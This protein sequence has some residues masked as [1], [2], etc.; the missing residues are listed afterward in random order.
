M[1]ASEILPLS[2]IETPN[3]KLQTPKKSQV[4]SS[5]TRP[6]LRAWNLELGASLVFGAWCLGFGVSFSGNAFAWRSPEAHGVRVRLG[7]AAVGGSGG[8]CEAGELLPRNCSHSQTKLHRLPSSREI[9]RRTRPDH[10]RPFP[11]GWEAWPGVQAGPCGRKPRNRGSQR[12][13]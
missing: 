10:L 3:T 5:K 13:G 8:R 4:P 1:R 11:K 9:E 7:V 6:A 12:R 2:G